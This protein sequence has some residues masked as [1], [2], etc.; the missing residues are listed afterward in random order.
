MAAGILTI[1]IIIL[2]ASIIRTLYS[3]LTHHQLPL[4]KREEDLTNQIRMA[5]H[6]L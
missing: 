1:V 4:K 6:T 3:G 2:I 5:C